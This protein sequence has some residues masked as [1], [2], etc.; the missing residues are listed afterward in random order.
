MALLLCSRE[1]EDAARELPALEVLEGAAEVLEGVA[2]GD[3]LVDLQPAAEIEVR[4]HREV[5]ARPRGAVAAAEDRLV[6]VERMHDELEA[7]P[8]LRH[9]DDRERTARPERVERLADHA[10]VADRL[11]RVIGAA[12]GELLDDGHRVL[13]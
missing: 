11:E 8:E 5:A 6:L 10:G 9:A 7:R 1:S 3:E 4:Q 13:A 12:A 2:A